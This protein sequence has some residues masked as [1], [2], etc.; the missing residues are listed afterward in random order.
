MSAIPNRIRLLVRERDEW[1]CTRCGKP[2]P[3]HV[4]QVHH[5]KPR[6]RG[7]SRAPLTH[8]PANLVTLCLD[9]HAWVERF[10]LSA[11]AL[12]WLLKQWQDPLTEPVFRHGSWQQPGELWT[13]A[14][15]PREVATA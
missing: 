1:Q 12:G 10:R 2:C 11:N 5:R 8:H 7:S 4:G 3:K 13:P 9:C 14:T 6:G 15:D